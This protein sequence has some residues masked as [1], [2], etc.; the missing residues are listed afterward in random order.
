ME[1]DQGRALPK[2]EK[3]LLCSSS[4]ALHEGGEGGSA[5]TGWDHGTCDGG[6]NTRRGWLQLGSRSLSKT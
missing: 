5:I 6:H 1:P 2:G 3:G 4:V